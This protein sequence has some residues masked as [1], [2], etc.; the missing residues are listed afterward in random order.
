MVLVNVGT[1]FTITKFENSLAVLASIEIPS[2]PSAPSPPA[3][4]LSEV[5]RPLSSVFPATTFGSAVAAGPVGAA[6]AAAVEVSAGLAVAVSVAAGAA[7]AAD[8]Y[9]EPVAT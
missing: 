2:Y 6:G 3:V 8:G 9:L 7:G 4:H 1:T 5:Q